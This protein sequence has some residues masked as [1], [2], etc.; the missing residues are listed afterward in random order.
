MELVG[1]VC[2]SGGRGGVGVGSSSCCCMYEFGN[3]CENQD[4]G[5]FFGIPRLDDLSSGS[6]VFMRDVLRWPNHPNERWICMYTAHSEE[7]RPF[8]VAVSDL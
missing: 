6:T 8:E 5:N 4:E 3:G 1:G 2:A 7:R